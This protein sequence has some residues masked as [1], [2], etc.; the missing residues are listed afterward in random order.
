MLARENVA[1]VITEGGGITELVLQAVR[2]A[3]PLNYVALAVPTAW[4]M[5]NWLPPEMFSEA[6]TRVVGLFL[7]LGWLAAFVLALVA[8]VRHFSESGWRGLAEPRVPIIFAI[9]GCVFVW[10]AS[11]LN[12]N[13]Y[14]AAHVLPMSLVAFALAWSLPKTDLT[15]T[16]RL[17]AALPL[18]FVIAAALSQVLVLGASTT[19]LLRAAQVPGYPARQPFSV[20]IAGYD[21]VEL[22]IERAMTE[23]GIP[24]DHPLQRLLI[25]DLTYLAL[26]R[27]HLPLHRLGVLS[28][29]NGSIDEPVTYL[30]S[31]DSDGVIVGC[32][33]LPTDM[34]AAASRSGEICA[35]SRTTLHHLAATRG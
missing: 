4:P 2:G 17:E 25:D 33:Y 19:P 11:Q 23:A 29:W 15:G 1:A 5:S 8:L 9:L 30:R 6:V 35:L 18:V 32:Q 26:Q 14:E 10:G 21:T 34:R 7:Y 22:D 13:A 31:R 24:T 12:K 3:N 28:T 27:H 20:S 16:S